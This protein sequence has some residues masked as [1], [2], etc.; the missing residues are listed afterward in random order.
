[1]KFL[2]R[3]PISV[4]MVFTA[5]CLIGLASYSALP[6][7]LLPSIPIPEITVQVTGE[8][9]SAREIEDGVVA[10]LRR[11]LLVV[12]GLSDIKS[13]TEDGLG[14]LRLRFRYGT[15][16]DLALIDVNERIDKIAGQLPDGIGRPEATKSSAT[17]I[18]VMTISMTLRTD[19]PYAQG[20]AQKFLEMSRLA[21]EV[22]RRRIEQLPEVAMVDISG[23]PEQELVLMP[24]RSK[25]DEAGIT[26]TDL[27]TAISSADI[28]P[29]T[30]TVREG[31]Y[32]YSLR[33]GSN[34]RSEQDVAGIAFQHAGRMYRISDFCQ[35]QLSAD[36]AKG[37]RLAGGKRAIVMS[38]IKREAT[39]MGS[40][41]KDL[42][43]ALA[44][45]SSQYPDIGFNVSRSQT[46]LLDDAISSLV[47]NFALGFLL[48]FLSALFFMGNMRTPLAMGISLIVAL[49]LT[50]LAFFLF[51]HSVNIISL[52]G[53]ILVVGMM[54]DNMIV[55]T[56]NI[57]QYERR[58]LSLLEACRRGTAEMITPTL[59][60]SLTTIVVFAPLM[61]LSD[62]AGAL[63]ADQ[64]FAITAG[65]AASYVVS[66][67][68]LPIVYMGLSKVI[69]D[70]QN[71]RWAKFVAHENALVTQTYDS[72]A[73]RFFAH[74]RKVVLASA[75][76]L[77]LCLVGYLLLPKEQ[78]PRTSHIEM[79]VNI[80]WNENIGE[81]ENA[82]RVTELLSGLRQSS[83][84]AAIGTQR[85]S[86]SELQGLCSNEALLFMNA[87]ST[88][89]LELLK[90]NLRHYIDRHYPVA[91]MQLSPADNIFDRLFPT[92]EPPLEVRLAYENAAEPGEKQIGEQRLR[93]MQL[94][95]AYT[96][97]IA[98]QNQIVLDVDLAKAALYGVDKNEIVSTLSQ[99]F[100]S[101]ALGKLN[102][103]EGSLRIVAG[104]EDKDYGHYMANAMVHAA[105]SEGSLIP[106][107]A[108]VHS[109]PAAGPKKIMAGKDGE[110]YPFVFRNVDKAEKR[111]AAV[112][113]DYKAGQHKG[114]KA[115]ASGDYVGSRQL[116]LG[117]MEI[118]LVS[119]LLMY[120]V[121]CA[122]FESFLQPLIVLAEIP[123]DVAFALL[124]LWLCGYSLN[125][126]SCIG[127]IASCGIVINDSILKIDTINHLR[128]DGMPM[129]G[130]IH[131]AGRRRIRA[132][133]MTTLTTL[134]CMV[135]FF[136]T[137]DLT[138]ELQRPLALA[139]I[140]ALGIGTLVSIFVVPLLYSL[141][142]HD[143]CTIQ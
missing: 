72:I 63:F 31:Y 134:L 136:L 28:S 18:P 41:E 112:V 126:M 36:Q 12:E 66:I 47:Q 89:S 78:M 25:M 103:T 9:K 17:D 99:G 104:D 65:L 85:S 24:D 22:V 115:E 45:F 29:A 3:H 39:K 8:N 105:G 131:T 69:S 125:I 34:L 128:R 114:W 142:Y 110:Y 57:E 120:F 59:S 95:D 38:V 90:Q 83:A 73:D 30:M 119:L 23:L 130:A 21:D 107:T 4:C 43:K 123:I 19:Q 133:L 77:P 71:S 138:S 51:G 135:P 87:G 101:A 11:Q 122:Q 129:L 67:V 106:L 118:L 50:L 1:M 56:E 54:I 49:I 117:M 109:R 42:N 132:I 40:L 93:L 44:D 113:D 26:M 79:N 64:V 53:L 13:E 52:S 141:F 61:F 88:D 108:F 62:M 81:A 70:H 86:L 27:S 91:V 33:L 139:M 32:E 10:P 15:D 97:P 76:A 116:V 68:L 124:V 35:V 48:M 46:Q 55:V 7:S 100:G 84:S 102:T 37:Q 94:T 143:V 98:M 16:I 121:L 111:A 58:G 6:V 127:I 82:R 60:S 14:I 20:N 137:G 75:L 5:L 74:P 140:A 2:L 80:D 96:D 92:D